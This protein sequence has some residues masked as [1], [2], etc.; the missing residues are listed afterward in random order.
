MPKDPNSEPLSLLRWVPVS[1]LRRNEYN[2]NHVAPPELELLKL[3]ILEDGW[4]QPI[5]VFERS[6]TELVIVDGEHR[7][8]VAA[9]ET[10]AARTGGLVPVV[11]IRGKTEAD[12]MIATVRH[13]RAR[14]E[15]GVIPMA[16]IVGE[17]LKVMSP[18]EV[19][20]LS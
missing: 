1:Y 5:V 19:A 17:L 16:N 10:I 3:S 13:N 18:E 2:P 4:T 8:G 14:G 7:S 12:L 11:P 20:T 15:H 9:D 6:E